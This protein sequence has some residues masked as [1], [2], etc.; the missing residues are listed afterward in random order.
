LKARL[1]AAFGFVSF[2]VLLMAAV[3]YAALEFGT[4]ATREVADRR[5]PAIQ[6][7]WQ[8]KEALVEGLKNERTMMVGT[9]TA[10]A[11]EF[12][13]ARLK[14]AWVRADEGRK[15]YEPHV[16]TAEKKAIW[17]NVTV[18]YD[19]YRKSEEEFLVALGS[20][21]EGEKESAYEVSLDASE[22]YTKMRDDLFR[23]IAIETKQ[24]EGVRGA[25][26][27]RSRSILLFLLVAGAAG[28]A[29]SLAVGTALAF[30]I[31]RS[32][33]HAVVTLSDGAGQVSTAAS[34]MS[35]A[36]QALSGGA[37]SQAAALQ[38]TSAAMEELTVMTH[39][40]AENSG[41]ANQ[42]SGRTCLDV[43]SANASMDA[44]VA[45]MAEISRMGEETGKIVKT[46]DEIAFQT[47]LLALNASVEAARAGD[48]GA[49]FAVV[50]DEVRTLAQRAA[51]AAKNTSDLIEGTVAKIE[52][53]KALVQ[54]ADAV[55]RQLAA[56]MKRVAELV[57]EISAASSEQSKGIEEI[58]NAVRNVDAVTQTT[59][60]QS[61]EI[62]AAAE[63]LSAQSF[64]LE[65]V[66][67]EIREI[68]EG[69]GADGGRRASARALPSAGGGRS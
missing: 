67:T 35:D 6:G 25:F 64:T 47:N 29:L 42:L 21:S 1:F 18:L 65:E 43:E 10:R 58:N 38:Q 17:D 30:S 52:G 13:K 28:I 57:A 59:A 63:E 48:A 9:T 23:L 24:A 14:E 2:V 4:R 16:D 31:S 8:M 11:I 69:R 46:I 60:A 33:D 53:G 62:A 55:F 39:H 22:Y 20:G 56:S 5:L 66:V 12:Q 51:S 61:E 54:K 34:E 45:A 15:I 32:L 36:S 19:K 68:V 37:S 3:G 49:G 44:L 26:H 41:M 40:N 27:A 7:L 50:A